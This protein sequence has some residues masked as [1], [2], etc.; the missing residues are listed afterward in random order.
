MA[1]CNVEDG[2]DHLYKL[3]LIG[4]SCVGKSSLLSRFARGE[5]RPDYNSTTTNNVVARDVY[6][7]GKIIKA[8]IVDIAGN[9]KYRDFSTDVQMQNVVGALIVYDVSRCSTFED[10]E[11]WYRDLKIANGEIEVTLVLNKTDLVKDSVTSYSEAGKS[12]AER[13]LVGLIETSAK[14]GRNV[15]KAFAELIGR[16]FRKINNNTMGAIDTHAISFFSQA[17]MSRLRG[18]TEPAHYMLKIESFSLLSQAGTPKFESDIFEASGYKWR[19]ELYPNGNEEENGGGNISIYLTIC[20]TQSLSKG[21]EV[22]VDYA[23]GKRGRFYEKQIK[24]GFSKLI[25]LDSFC[26]AVNGCIYNDSCVFGV[27][28][29][30]VPRYTETDRCLSMIKPSAVMSTHTWTIENFSARTEHE[31]LSDDFKVGK[32]KWELALYPKG[33]GK[34]KDT[35]LSIYLC[36]HDSESLTTGWRIYAKFKIRVKHHCGGADIETGKFH[37]YVSVRAVFREVQEVP[38]HRAIA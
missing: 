38:L 14:D 16:I 15:E 33:Y 11:R 24:W 13:V 22:C 8:Q 5:F 7:D 17:R 26:N 6:V 4:D 12:F 18:K 3:L 20:D 10:V 34:G 30:S 19:L 36:V 27:E 9:H 35:H 28:V 25:S 29:F 2:H 1:G 37:I 32:V 31:L 21:W 23:D